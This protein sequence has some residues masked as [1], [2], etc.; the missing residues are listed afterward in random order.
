MLQAN[1][2]RGLYAIIP[3]PAH[4]GAERFD[5][6]HTVDLEETARLVTRLIGDGCDG[7]IALGTT[8]ECA[9][10]S[11]E[12]YEAFVGC[13]T[14]VVNKRIPTFFGASAMGGHE[15]AKRMKFLCDR[16]VE[17][18][19]LGLP[20]W[21]PLTVDT[22]VNFYSA[23]GGLFP[24]IA[25]MVYANERAFRFSFP[26]EFW[27]AV[28]RVAPTVT[29]AKYA[30]PKDL[31]RLLAVTGGRINIIPNEMSIAHFFD[32]APGSTTACWA[33]AASMGPKPTI[34]LMRAVERQDIE[35][36][37][38]LSG[39]MAWANAP[40]APIIA[41]KEAFTLYNIQIEKTRIN[42]AGYCNAGPVRPPYGPMPAHYT[43]ASEECGRRW[44]MLSARMASGSAIDDLTP[45]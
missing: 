4:A 9:T 41:D 13:V 42:A 23:L 5:A 11:Q 22:A 39:A 16:D 38:R 25:I 36:V 15:V 40:V 7:L 6:C 14:E 20:M 33:T 8:G 2:I 44:G 10:L 3:T 35:A 28:A 31:K 19:L 45:V 27:E 17:G 26:D 32:E 43:Q 24:E 1:D 37:K 12:D 34:E 29:S 18:T 30:R 21:Q